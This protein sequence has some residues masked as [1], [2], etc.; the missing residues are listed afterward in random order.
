MASIGNIGVTSLLNSARASKRRAQALEDGVSK[1]EWDSSAKTYGDYQKYQSHLESRLSASSDPSKRLSLNVALRSAN[2]GFQGAEIQRSTIDVLAGKIT[3]RDKYNQLLGLYYQAS[4]LGDA[5]QVQDLTQQLNSLSVKITN[6]EAALA[7]SAQRAAEIANANHIKSVK[8]GID[9]FVGS[10][11][12]EVGSSVDFIEIPPT[13]ENPKGKVVKSITAINQDFQDTGNNNYFSDLAETVTEMS[14][15]LINSYN[16]TNEPEIKNDISKQYDKIT[17]SI[18]VAGGGTMTLKDIQL[19]TMAQNAGNSM[20]TVASKFDT[21][22]NPDGTV[23]DKRVFSIVK[24]KIND[25]IYIRQPDGTIRAQLTRTTVAP[26][27]EKLSTKIDDNGNIVK[28]SDPNYTGHPDWTIEQRLL[29]HGISASSNS[30]GTVTLVLP[31]HNGPVIGTIQPDG[32]VRYA[33]NPNEFSAGQPGMYEISPT[34]GIERSVSPGEISDFGTAHSFPSALG[35]SQVNSLFGIGTSNNGLNPTVNHVF[36]P[37]ELTPV[38]RVPLRGASLFGGTVKPR[39]IELQSQNNATIAG[40]VNLGSPTNVSGA[41]GLGSS[42]LPGLNQTPIRKTR[43]SGIKVTNAPKTVKALPLA[44][45]NKQPKVTVA[46]P[47]KQPQVT[48]A[49]PHKQ[50]QV[51]VTGPAPT[52]TP[53]PDNGFRFFN[54]PGVQGPVEN[55]IGN[56]NKNTNPI[57]GF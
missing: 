26:P 14:N 53:K 13:P 35:N 39:A 1:F 45:P 16:G 7:A 44:K 33:G 57:T 46:K 21:V 56:V 51:V 55:A 3:D 19:Q 34:V 30:D 52:P 20:F 37:G 27:D 25:F 10:G 38:G 2:R 50:P 42:K 40:L 47:K 15:Y 32:T 48:V 4:D 28:R 54:D 9:A 36:Q 5:N 29:A 18:P 24:N 6:E 12:G 17:K 49:K 41:A 43:E 8:A 31:G 23:Q 22:I 11:I